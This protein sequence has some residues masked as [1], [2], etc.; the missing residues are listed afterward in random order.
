MLG[1]DLCIRSVT[2]A[3]QNILNI[4]ATDM[5]RPIGELHLGLDLSG[6][7][8]TISDVIQNLAAKEQEVCSRDG[9]RRYSMRVRPYRTTGNRI[10]GVVIVLI[11][12]TDHVI[13]VRAEVARQY[14]EG[15]VDAVRGPLI[16]L[17]GSLRVVSANGSKPMTSD[18][19]VVLFR[20]VREV[21]QNVVKHAQARSVDVSVGRDGETVLVEVQDDGVGFDTEKALAIHDANGGFGLFD[22]RERLDYLGGSLTVQSEPGNGTT[23]VLRVP[24]VP[25]KACA[26]GMSHGDSGASG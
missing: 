13:M 10:D 5:G 6:L 17:D 9:G 3:A 21:L 25:E 12:V 4:R 15:I 18:V 26:E 24:L 2:P 22:V 11:D 8:E 19:R 7:E 1:A 23:A 14:A 20:G 16:V